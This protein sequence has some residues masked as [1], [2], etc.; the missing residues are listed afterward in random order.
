MAFN[1]TGQKTLGDAP[2]IYEGLEFHPLLV[3]DYNHYARAKQAME[4]MQ[5]SL[6]PK[7]ARLSW[8]QCLWA[9]DKECEKQTGKIGDFLVSVMIV[10]ARA[11]RLEAPGNDITIPLRPVFSQDGLLT[12]LMVGEMTGNYVL[13]DMQKMDVVRRIIADQNDYE[14]PDENWNPELVRAAQMN[15]ENNSMGLKYDFETLLYSVAVNAHC[16][17]KD[18]YEWTIKEFHGMQDAIDRTLGYQ[19]FTLAEK[20]GFVTFPKGNPYPT[21]KFDRKSELPTGFKTI[22]ELDAGSKGL[23]AEH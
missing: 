8:C 17:A 11:L 1:T 15:A 21:W 5:S 7:L 4:L 20:S 12:A 3:G 2:V 22:A 23:L 16:R 14:I 18:I 19:I 9:L 6:H 10:L 13:L